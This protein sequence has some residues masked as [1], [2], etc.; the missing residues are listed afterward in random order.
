MVLFSTSIVQES[1][2]GATSLRGFPISDSVS[3]CISRTVSISPLAEAAASGHF[4]KD[5]IHLCSESSSIPSSALE[6]IIPLESSH[7]S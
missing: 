7:L 6:Q 3:H 5:Q 1:S 2:P 4:F